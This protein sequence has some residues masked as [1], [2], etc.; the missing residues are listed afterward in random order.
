MP[1]SLIAG[2]PLANKNIQIKITAAIEMQAVRKKFYSYDFAFV[3]Q[4]YVETAASVKK[5]QVTM[6]DSMV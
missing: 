3:R 5:L 2:I 4:L 6:G 1:I